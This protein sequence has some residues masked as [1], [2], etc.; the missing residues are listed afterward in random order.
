LASKG[1]QDWSPEEFGTENYGFDVP[2]IL[3]CRTPQETNPEGRWGSNYCLR[4]SPPNGDVDL[5]AGSDTCQGTQGTRS[6]GH[7]AFHRHGYRHI[8][9]QGCL[10]TWFLLGSWHGHLDSAGHG[11]R[12]GLRRR[13]RTEIMSFPCSQR[14]AR[15]DIRHRNQDYITQCSK[16]KHLNQNVA[17]RDVHFNVH[18]EVEESKKVLRVWA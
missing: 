16:N 3:Q 10:L 6:T 2:V 17:S 18:G 7:A 11:C 13:G 9:G 5:L 15:S 4:I 12:T 14:A 8:A 1:P